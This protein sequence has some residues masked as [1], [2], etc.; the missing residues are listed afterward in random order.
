MRLESVS[1]SVGAEAPFR[2]LLSSDNHL[3][4]CD[5]SEAA[6]DPRKAELARK[7]SGVFPAA[8]PSFAAFS[9]LV[10]S[11]PG[12]LLLHAGDLS[13]F[14]SGANLAA[15]A[16]FWREAGEGRP[17]L[18]APGNHEFSLYVGEAP[19]GEAYKEQSAGRVRAAWPNDLP[20]ASLVHGGVL[21]VALDNAY[22]LVSEAQRA[23]FR[24]EAARGLPTV[25]L[26]HN[27]F[28]EED[29]AEKT[30]ADAHGRAAFLCGAPD[31][32]LARFSDRR[33]ASVQAPDATTRAFLADL[34]A[35]PGLRAVLAGHVHRFHAGELFPGVPQICSGAGFRGEA[36]ELLFHD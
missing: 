6:R 11:R 26:C 1:L 14:V 24:R 3:C 31:A 5:A 21:F 20:L 22:Y 25:L 36:T 27:P 4:R 35:T 16:A 29:L 18:A 7:R 19:E 34:R 15:A 13:D 17:V 33:A 30:L 23:A 32:A 10:R 9:A 8:E 12:E 28:W 2:A